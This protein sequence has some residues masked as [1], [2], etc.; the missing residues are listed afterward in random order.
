MCHVHIHG[1]QLL[2]TCAIMCI[3]VFLWRRT[4]VRLLMCKDCW[5]V[6]GVK[7][8]ASFV[9]GVQSESYLCI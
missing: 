7:Q 2:N 9:A 4:A 1:M 8:K 3:S 5:A 6:A